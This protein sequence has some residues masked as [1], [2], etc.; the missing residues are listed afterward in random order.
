MAETSTSSSS[1]SSSPI[2]HIDEDHIYSVLELLPFDSILSFS[3]TCRRF[4]SIASSD[5]LWRSICRR[6]WGYEESMNGPLLE[7]VGSWKRLYEKVFRMGSVSCVR[8][9]ARE[10][11]GA[12]PRARASHSLNFISDCLVLFG[13]GCEGGR[14]LD[15]TW[16]AY[17]GNGVRWALSWKQISSGT[18]PGRFGQTCTI[19][20]DALVLFG[21]INDNG[22][23]QNDTWVGQIT[24]DENLETKI[25]WRLLEVASITPPP[26]GAHAECCIGNRFLVIYG[27]IGLDGLR[28]NDT[29]MLDLSNGPRSAEWREIV[30]LRSPSARSGHS[31]TWV[32]G[33]C[34]ALFG[35]RGNGY[36]VLGDVWLLDIGGE[37]PEWMELLYDSCNTPD[38][39]SLPRVGH[40]STPIVGGRVLIYGGED[41]HRHRKDDFW[42]LDINASPTIKM[43]IKTAELKRSPMWKRLKAEGCQPGGRSFHRACIDR[44]GCRVYVFGGMVDGVLQPAEALGLRFDGELY[45]LEVLG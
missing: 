9:S 19:V 38:M 43:R 30:T 36:E 24:R 15:D 40:S 21:G 44:S 42:V 11:D 5:S 32:G 7:G 29:W 22:I 31:L 18:P 27:G 26:R 3:M 6:D 23:R 37:H 2:T 4:R 17:I 20:S 41:T 28:L 45:L 16:V 14:H 13:G 35:G 12:S 10:G 33:T 25:S 1:M 34:I 8:L 39:A